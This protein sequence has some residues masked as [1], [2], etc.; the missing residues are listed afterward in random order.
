DPPASGT[1]VAVAALLTMFQPPLVNASR[2]DDAY[3][4]N[5]AGSCVYVVDCACTS[6]ASSTTAV[7]ATRDTRPLSER[8][9]ANMQPPFRRV[10]CRVGTDE[11]VSLRRSNCN[12]SCGF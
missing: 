10:S 7:A 2:V 12:A 11:S 5:P 6:A 4:T 8:K 3:G 9:P 1:I